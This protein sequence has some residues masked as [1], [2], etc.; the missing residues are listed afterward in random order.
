MADT[1]N[2]VT[3]E[4]LA[5]KKRKLLEQ[6][7]EEEGIRSKPT[8]TSGARK[9]YPQ[10]PLSF[11]QQRLWLLDQLEPGSPFYNL[12]HPVRLKGKL[13]VAVLEASLNQVAERH[14]SLRTTFH[15]E[16]GKPVQRIHEKLDLRIAV[17]DLSHQPE[18]EQK[19]QA[20]RLAVEEA[21]RPFDLQ[22]GPLLRVYLLRLGA[23]DRL[24]LLAAY[25]LVLHCYSGQE[26]IVVG[27][28]IA[29]RT[30]P[31]IERLIGYFANTLV[32]RTGLTGELSVFELLQRVRET[33]LD[34]YAHQDVPFEKLLEE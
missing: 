5:L 16:N 29:N 28:P 14:E 19:E 22:R 3:S 25:K 20:Q 27:T 10:L 13:D 34:A 9:N 30:Q 32:L 4:M 21:R 17:T 6:W 33:A 12:P 7:L 24:L 15:E 11:A 26:D 18:P 31:E 8:I 2:L 1:G 23:E